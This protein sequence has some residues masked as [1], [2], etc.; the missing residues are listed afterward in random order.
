[1]NK[2]LLLANAAAVAFSCFSGSTVDAMFRRPERIKTAGDSFAQSEAETEVFPRVRIAGNPQDATTVLEIA[3]FFQK[4]QNQS[5]E[6]KK[7]T[8]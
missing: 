6:F 8:K 3:S 4:A 7:N 2:K 1:M 5:G